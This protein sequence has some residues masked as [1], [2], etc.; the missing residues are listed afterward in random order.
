LSFS[1][2]LDNNADAGWL[3]TILPTILLNFSGLTRLDNNANALNGLLQST[4]SSIQSE[5][6][7]LYNNID[8]SFSFFATF[9]EK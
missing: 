5:R 9:W 7:Y 3:V 2:S 4:I 1:P 6:K 8:R